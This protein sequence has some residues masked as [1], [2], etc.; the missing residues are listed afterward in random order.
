MEDLQNRPGN[1]NVLQKK[2]IIF[3]GPVQ[4]PIFP[5]VSCYRL[6]TIREVHLKTLINSRTKTIYIRLISKCPDG[7]F[8]GHIKI[9]DHMGELIHETQ[10][11]PKSP[12]E[13]EQ[14]LRQFVELY[15]NNDPLNS[16]VQLG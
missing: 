2:I 15:S 10:F 9:L 16:T 14:F 8:D 7:S 5:S 1:H 3:V 11:H 13:A 6:G 4:V 12:N